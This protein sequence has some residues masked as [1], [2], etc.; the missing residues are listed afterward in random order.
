MKLECYEVDRLRLVPYESFAQ[1]GLVDLCHRSCAGNDRSPDML[2]INNANFQTQH[3][4]RYNILLLIDILRGMDFVR[5]ILWWAHRTPENI[6]YH[7]DR[8]HS[9]HGYTGL[10]PLRTSVAHIL[11]NDLRCVQEM[12]QWMWCLLRPPCLGTGYVRE[13]NQAGTVSISPV[14]DILSPPRY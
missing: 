9:R 11:R 5:Q 2:R 1:S 14:Y 3:A 12:R 7:I 6:S 10:P 4:H 8:R 13:P